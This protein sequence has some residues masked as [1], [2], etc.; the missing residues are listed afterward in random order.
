MVYVT[1]ICFIAAAIAIIINKY[2]KMACYFLA[3][4]LICIILTIHL[5]PAIKDGNYPQLLKDGALAM[6]AINYWK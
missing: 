2:K 3:L 5:T 4:L 1:G 6:A